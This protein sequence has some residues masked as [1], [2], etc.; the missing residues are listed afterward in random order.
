MGI[1]IL[2]YCIET[3]GKKQTQNKD[4]LRGVEPDNRRLVGVRVRH[5]GDEGGFLSRNGGVASFLF[6]TQRQAK[7][8]LACTGYPS[9]RGKHYKQGMQH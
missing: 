3:V 6:C 5:Q 2:K 8:M 1:K 9:E 4:S 7:F